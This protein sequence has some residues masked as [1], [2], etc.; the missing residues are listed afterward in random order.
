MFLIARVRHRERKNAARRKLCSLEPDR[1]H[2]LPQTFVPLDKNTP[3]YFPRHDSTVNLH[4]IWVN[5]RVSFARRSDELPIF[6]YCSMRKNTPKYNEIRNFVRNNCWSKWNV[7]LSDRHFIANSKFSMR[8]P[9]TEIILTG[10]S[11][12]RRKKE[13]RHHQLSQVFTAR[14]IFSSLISF[15]P[16]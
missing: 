7:I 3:P 2:V 12:S 5:E 14:S 1:P 13:N 4:S 15:P 6:L 9:E 11:A 16:S 10:D 8:W